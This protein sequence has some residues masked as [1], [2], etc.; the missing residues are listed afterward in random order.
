MVQ[1][2]VSTCA[3]VVRARIPEA[4]VTLGTSAPMVTLQ[5]Q[6]ELS[7][8]AVHHYAWMHPLDELAPQFPT[9]RTGLLEEFPSQGGAAQV[10]SYLSLAAHVGAGGALMWNLASG[11][12]DQAMSYAQR[13]GV[14]EALSLWHP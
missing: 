5:A 10:T 12:D 6:P 14:L 4:L 9:G 3:R 2:F 1:S 11:V 7:Y 8:T 13:N